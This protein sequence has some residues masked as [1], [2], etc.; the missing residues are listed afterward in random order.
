MDALDILT[1]L[2]NVLPFFQPIF[3]ADEH[4]VIGYEV[5]GRYYNGSEYI[6]LGPFFHDSN[7]PEEYR[8]EVDQVVLKKALDR[9]LE[10]DE[11]LLIFINR[12]ADLLM[13]GA[14]DP[15]LEVLHEYEELGLSLN[16]YVLEI[17]EANYKGELDQLDHFLNYLKTLGIKIAIDK[18]GHES[19]HLDRI[20]QLSPNILKVDLRALRS[21]RAS[22]GFQDILYSLS[23]LARKIGAILLFENIEM[24]YQLQFAWKNGGRYYQ[25]FY[26]HKPAKDFVDRNILKDKLKEEFHRFIAFE[27][28]RIETLHQITES[29]QIRM[30]DLVSKYKKQE[31]YEEFLGSLTKELDSIAFR[32][33]ICD[34]DGFQVSPNLF[35]GDNEW[36][37]QVEY[38]NK[39][40]SWRP[41][42]LENIHKM[43]L[44]KKGILS[45]VYSDIE[46][47][48]NIRTFSY[49]LSAKHY[50]FIDLSYA[51][52]YDNDGLL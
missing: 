16:R 30:Q 18:L 50:L 43:R 12:D 46:I 52:L 51:F 9:F 35:K 27:K 17:S 23:L 20:G 33:Y 32:L 29:F 7:I 4:Q 13:K 14:D 21:N 34:E 47:G 19:S 1:D 15:F 24:V 31:K 36:V 48:D 25:G 49:P 37:S 28:K 40:W 5:L 8:T 11:H 2:E 38:M 22:Q 41:Y 3:S 42:F 39:N 45:D 44:E 10:V 6:S 26:L